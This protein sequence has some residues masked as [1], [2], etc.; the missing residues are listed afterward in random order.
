[1]VSWGRVVGRGVERG[2]REEGEKGP[3]T[4]FKSMYESVVSIEQREFLVK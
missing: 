3:I 1:M 2:R 4:P